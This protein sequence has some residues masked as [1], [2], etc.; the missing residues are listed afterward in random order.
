MS[1]EYCLKEP[2]GDVIDILQCQAISA[3]E[4]FNCHP[5][6]S[7]QRV[8]QHSKNAERKAARQVGDNARPP[9]APNHGFVPGRSLQD[10][11]CAVLGHGFE[12]LQKMA[13]R[14]HLSPGPSTLRAGGLPAES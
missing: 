14:L 10:T 9:S 4:H 3:W 13:F 8:T 12:W 6:G 1:P 5:L 2:V 7:K 11:P